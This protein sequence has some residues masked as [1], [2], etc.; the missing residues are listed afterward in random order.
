M[1]ID[2]YIAREILLTLIAV[3]FVLLAIFMSNRLVRYLA[4]ATTGG[5]SHELVLSMLALKTLSTLTIILPIA[6]F[7]A[8]L[9]AFSRL[10]K[11][12]E[13]TAMVACGVNMSWIYRAVMVL[14]LIVAGV[15]GFIAI[16][17]APWAE[18]KIYQIS[19]DFQARPVVSGLAPGRFTGGGGEGVLYFQRLADDGQ[20]MEQVFIQQQRGAGQI[21]LVAERGYRHQDDEGRLLL[22]FENGHRYEGMPGMADFRIIEFE[23]HA[24]RLD[25]P[26]VSPSFRRQRA[27]P[28]AE[29]IGSSDVANIA[30]LQ[31]RISMPIS[32]LL[33]ALL[34]VPLSRT[35][36]RQGRYAKLF[37]AILVY[38]VYNNL[39][40]MAN[41]WIANGVIPPWLG[42]WWVHVGMLVGT[43]LLLVQQYGV[44]WSLEVLFGRRRRAPA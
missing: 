40:G 30:E 6:F 3:L 18:E 20:S 27:L 28:T 33:L 22:V 21:V 38:L 14:A 11:D 39:M 9:L 43:W 8:I 37:V 23:Q 26:D 24:V 12:S 35:S 17:A 15:V 13:M 5:L 34:A 10:Y 1:I 32:V 25:P 31:W 41:T 19:D 29:L 42:M 44:S 4:D 16:Q 7:I 36:P 2:R